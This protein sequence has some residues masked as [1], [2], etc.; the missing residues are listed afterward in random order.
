M[1]EEDK[2]EFLEEI[3]VKN[4]QALE[5]KDTLIAVLEEELSKFKTAGIPF[6]KISRE[7]RINYTDIEE[8]SF[9]NTIVTDFE[10][11]DTLPTFNVKWQNQVSVSKQK[12]Q[13]EK[14]KQW[15]QVRLSLDT[16]KVQTVQ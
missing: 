4:Q 9:A 10:E 2:A 13:L 5:E 16:L 11:I 15:L 6:E 8:L 12:E 1:T 14:L 3:Y 7:A